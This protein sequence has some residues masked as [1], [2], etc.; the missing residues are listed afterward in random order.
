VPKK[1]N[2]T[3]EHNAA[4]NGVKGERILREALSEHGL[5]L[6]K[7]KEHFK[8]ISH[9]Y[10]GTITFP[11]PYDDGTFQSDGFIPELGIIVEIKY[12]EAHG[13][14]EEKVMVD[15]E[16]IRDGVYNSKYPL[17]YFFWGTPEVPGT[18]TTGRCWAYVF[19]DKVKKEKLPVEVVFAT[20]N[21]GFNK[22]VRKMKK[23]LR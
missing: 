19:R 4:K 14:T 21:D 7:K 1:K 5:T 13:T 18:K 20:T 15:L 3:D 11:S 17:V 2:K 6:L 23:L 22:W 9:P 10:K 12:G 8:N 16:K